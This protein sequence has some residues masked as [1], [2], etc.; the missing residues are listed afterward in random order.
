MSIK[1]ILKPVEAQLE[2]YNARN[3]DVFIQNFSEDCICMDSEGNITMQGREA[4]QERYGQMFASSPSL[5]C[6]IVS[7]TVVGNFVF[8]EERVTGHAKN[9]SGESHVMALYTVDPATPLITK[10]QFFR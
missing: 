6:N 10:V 5:H 1:N 7:R 4:M 2:A 9:P 8:D 3:I